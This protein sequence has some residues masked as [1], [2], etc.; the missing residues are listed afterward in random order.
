MNG[1]KQQKAVGTK[2]TSTRPPLVFATEPLLISAWKATKNE[3]RKY[4]TDYSR[5]EN[6]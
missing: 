4:Y 3:Q 1:V 5:H 2:N 6:I